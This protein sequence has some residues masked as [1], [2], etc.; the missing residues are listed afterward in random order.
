MASLVTAGNSNSL[1]NVN[2]TQGGFRDQIAA[3]IDLNKQIVGDASTEPGAS[4]SIDPLSAPFVLY[5]NPYTGSDKFAAGSYNSYEPPGGSSQEDVIAAVLKRVEKQRLTCGYTPQ[6]P[7]KTV[8]RAAI[9][10]AIITSKI[11]FAN[12]GFSYQGDLVSIVTNAGLIDVLNGPGS[13]VTT[14]WTDGKEPTD[15]ELEAFNSSSGGVILPRGCSLCSLDLRK[16]IL[17]PTSVP[18]SADEAADYSN[19]SAILRMTGQG[20]Y[21][22]FTFKDKNNADSSHHLLSGFEFASIDDLDQFYSKIRTA[23]GGPNNTGN[24]S[25]TLAVKRLSEWQIVGPAPARAPK[26]SLQIPQKVLLLTFSIALSGLTTEWLARLLM[27]T[28]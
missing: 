25:N 17:R 1:D 8:N 11:Y 4:V 6:R 12:T 21:Y 18:V 28:R 16:T 24:I 14:E 26:Q 15:A 7:F 19:R 13:N 5:V 9:E 2:L 20:Y 27:E 10:V 3:L 22:G 23:F